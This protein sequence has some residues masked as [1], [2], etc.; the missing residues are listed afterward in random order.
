VPMHVIGTVGGT[1]FTIQP[2]MQV[3]VDE[4]KAIWS[5]GLA[6]RLK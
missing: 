5:T 1:R 2:I 3:A 4:L 6:S